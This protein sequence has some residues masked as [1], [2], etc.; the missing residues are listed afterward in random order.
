M[1]LIR[2]Y[3]FRVLPQCRDVSRRIGSDNDKGIVHRTSSAFSERSVQTVHSR[4][5]MSVRIM[6]GGSLL[7]ANRSSASIPSRAVTDF[8]LRFDYLEVS[9][10]TGAVVNNED[11]WNCIPCMRF[12]L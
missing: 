7:V 12:V 9:A 10:D 11:S 8:S 3:R 1:A 4:H 6:I 2:T 5:S